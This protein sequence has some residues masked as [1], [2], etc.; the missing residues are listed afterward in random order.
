MR[1]EISHDLIDRESRCKWIRVHTTLFNDY[2]IAYSDRESSRILAIQVRGV[3]HITIDRFRLLQGSLLSNM[4][5][6]WEAMIDEETWQWMMENVE[7]VWSRL[8]AR[9]DDVQLTVILEFPLALF[10]RA[11]RVAEK[12]R[13]SSFAGRSCEHM[14]REERSYRGMRAESRTMSVRVDRAALCRAARHSPLAIR[15]SPHLT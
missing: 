5:Q 15:R 2:C 10:H 3:L 14:R 13:T 12:S 9:V 6:V 8:L 11:I 4:V 7:S 1:H